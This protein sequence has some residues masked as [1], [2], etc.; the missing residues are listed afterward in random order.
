MTST[1]LSASRSLGELAVEVPGAAGVFERV[2]L[3][4][5]CGGKQTLHAAC[6]NKGLDEQEVLAALEFGQTLPAPS[7][8]HWQSQPLA[9]IIQHIIG[10]HH[11]YVRRE[12]PNL[13]RWL[14]K[15]VAA[16]GERHAEL[17]EIRHC[18]QAMASELA[19]HMA[20]EE[21]ILFPAINRLAEPRADA[22]PAAQCFTTIAQ[23]VA[24]M[25]AEHEHSGRD[26]AEMRR[27][28]ADYTP[29]PD[30]CATFRA[31][32]RGLEAFERDLHQHVH[33]ENNMLFPRALELERNKNARG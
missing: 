19:Q 23:P 29:P 6:A 25:V 18:F 26:L 31:L 9:E 1:T 21:L 10:S 33:L 3:D 5:C 15:V 20:K 27:A 12:L 22:R 13:E 4:F 28:S 16:H 2:G 17:L 14:D 24:M 8:Q 30:A 7:D 32:Y 11:A